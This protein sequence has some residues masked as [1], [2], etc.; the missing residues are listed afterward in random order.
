MTNIINPTIDLFLYDLRNSLGDD[1][2]DIEKNRQYFYQ[3]FHP[4]VQE[5][6]KQ[7]RQDRR[8]RR[9]NNENI[10]PDYVHLLNSFFTYLDPDTPL[11]NG[12]YYPVRLGDSYGLLLEV[13]TP[14]KKTP[15]YFGELKAKIQQK[16]GENTARLGQTWMLST[17]LPNSSKTTPEE[18]K[19]IAEKCLEAILPNIKN[20]MFSEVF[21]GR[22][23]FLGATIFEYSDNNLKPETVKLTDKEITTVVQSQHIIIAIYPDAETFNKLADFYAD[24][25]RLFYYHHKV[26]WAYGQTRI[27]SNEIKDKFSLI[28]T[29]IESVEANITQGNRQVNK[30]EEI[31]D[32]L[33]KFQVMINQYSNLL[34]N[35]KFQQG[36]IEINLSNYDKRLQTLQKKAREKVTINKTEIALF[37]EFSKLVNEK[38]L[39]QIT[40]DLQ[41]FDQGLKLLEGNINAIRSQVEIEKAKNDQNF[42]ELISVV[43]T[44]VA[45][46]SFMGDDPQNKCELIPL[47]SKNSP[48]CE[49]TLI[50]KLIIFFTA[51]IFVWF[52][53]KYILKRS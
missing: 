20:P 38:Y 39:L 21:N 48:V 34:N 28:K 50:L 37:E 7:D 24:W 42:Q 53:R 45:V 22:G 51:S 44:A 19:E 43:G 30:L 17:Y 1:E 32:V 13:A 52:F 41:N 11:E 27:L 49:N 8:E 47:L 5:K 9:G 26:V 46:V 10:E 14:D 40:R 15:E 25:M 4:T 35:L 6:L 16:L 36:T 3:K 31:S 2:K 33:S 29:T 12:Y 18:I 23:E